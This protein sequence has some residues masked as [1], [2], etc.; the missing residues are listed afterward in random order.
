MRL[1]NK[2][3]VPL[4]RFFYTLLL[5][6][7]G[8]SVLFF[9]LDFF[10]LKMLG[11]KGYLLL[12]VPIVLILLFLKRGRQIFEYDSD[13]EALNFKNRSIL[14]LVS[15]DLSDEF[16]KYKLMKYEILNGFFFKNLYVTITSKKSHSITLKYDISYLTKKERND[17]KISLNRTLKRNKEYK[18]TKKD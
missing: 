1:S 2:S 17:L 11:W 6:I 12:A 7:L 13:G 5:L 18:E 9:L 10:K 16:P 4:Y 8:V 14:P 15:R 3:K